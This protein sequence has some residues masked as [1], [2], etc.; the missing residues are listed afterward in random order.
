MVNL[1][2]FTVDRFGELDQPIQKYIIQN[3][4]YVSQLPKIAKVNNHFCSSH[5]TCV[6]SE[7]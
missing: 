6:T 2:G 5:K 3:V 7:D 1:S 4:D